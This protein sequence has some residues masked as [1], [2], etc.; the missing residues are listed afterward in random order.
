[1]RQRQLYDQLSCYVCPDSLANVKCTAL[2]CC[3]RDG[4]AKIVTDVNASSSVTHIVCHPEQYE[5]FRAQRNERF[6]AIVRPEWVFKTFLLQTLVSVDRF[7]ANPA[8]IFSSLVI[9]A[10]P[11]DKDPR[12]VIDGLISHF[13]GQTVESES[14]YIGATH[15]LSLDEPS[16]YE[17]PAHQQW[18]HLNYTD[19]DV[20]RG[21]QAWNLWLLERPAL[22]D[23]PLPSCVVAYLGKVTGLSEQHYVSYSWIEDCVRRK[24]RVPEGPFS[25]KSPGSTSRKKQSWKTRPETQLEDIGL[26]KC[27]HV[28][29]SAK[30]DAGGVEL[31]LA[32]KPSNERMGALEAVLGGAI[33]LLAQHIPPYLKEKIS[34]VLKS[35]KAKVAN[36][37]LGDSYQEIVK[38][39]V[40]NA[41]FVVCRY[42][43]GFEYEEA[44]RQNKRVVS[45]YWV[46]AGHSAYD[47]K[48][49]PFQEAISRPVKSFGGITGMQGFVITLSGY[50]SRTTP[51]REDIQ[52]AIHATG[53]CMLPVLSRTHSTHLLCYEPKGEKYKKAQS[54]RF[55]NIVNHQWEHVAEDAFRY[56]LPKIAESD[57]PIE[58]ATSKATSSS[59]A[60]S[61]SAPLASAT[62]STKALQQG[63]G[64]FDVDDILTELNE[65]TPG[66]K[67]TERNDASKKGDDPAQA[68]KEVACKL[69]DTPSTETKQE[70]R[71]DNKPKTRESVDIPKNFELRLGT[72][73]ANDEPDDEDD[74]G[75]KMDV[76][77]TVLSAKKPKATSAKTKK[78]TKKETAAAVKKKAKAA[79]DP[80]DVS[81]KAIDVESTTK[82]AATSAKRKRAESPPP[83]ATDLKDEDSLAVSDT[84]TTS[85]TK[86]AKKATPATSKSKNEEKEP[87][88]AKAASS[89]TT[90][91]G[92]SAFVF[93][94]TGS[95]EES[96]VN[97]SI[98]AGLG[99]TTSKTGRKFDH[100]STHIICSELK[101]TEKFVAGCAGGKWIL[102]PS[103]LEASSAAGHFVDEAP[104]EWG[105]TP[106]DAE[107]MDLRIWV[108][109]PMFWRK[110]RAEGKPG[111]FA[112]WRFLVHAK[113]VPPP[114]MC[115]RVIE[116]SNGIVVPLT[117]TLNLADIAAS[118]EADKKPL[119]ALV[120]ADLPA[121]DTWLKKFKAQKMNCINA[122][123]LIDYITKNQSKQPQM[124]D[125]RV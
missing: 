106:G 25:S 60:S 104:H 123:F 20:L 95:R 42:Q 26:A 109:A 113:C 70:N 78:S 47:D 23:Y 52:I 71:G 121:R 43:A 81:E 122:S 125:Y 59:D 53:A 51:T 77:S 55:E 110:A 73:S 32:R 99:G 27:A 12:K 28:Y 14:N 108:G 30:P 22:L 61:K 101:R 54:W 21:V 17:E 112:G 44:M 124:D 83:A 40:A 94:L 66:A 4:G 8:L 98:I 7:S 114:D 72:K 10:G 57:Q 37:P 89:K 67:E 90:K 2:Q 31:T 75:D 105:A 116:A 16:Q 92:G 35:V 97:E 18:F 96:A 13:G 119:V 118:A 88:T 80:A 63:G 69:F 76:D 45:I 84:S 49:T 120:P 64:R 48:Q 38:K 79:E 117:K 62:P 74:V 6:I 1:M 91:K 39:V 65:P 93:L 111:A 24:T 103:Y 102:K 29:Q 19:N 115:E 36:V 107:F 5:R 41:S 56:K 85:K 100:T 34:E 33:V 15:I 82:K 3:L 11:I 58:A 9:A 50:S 87:P 86:K 68:P 46:L